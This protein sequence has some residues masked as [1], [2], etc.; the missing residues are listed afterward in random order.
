MDDSPNTLLPIMAPSTIPWLGFF[1]ETRTLFWT[2]D[3]EFVLRRRL[4]LDDL[5]CC[6]S[7]SESESDE[8]V[9]DERVKARDELGSNG[10]DAVVASE[11]LIA[12]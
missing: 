6:D 8:L 5:P 9:G 7:E 12:C 10:G 2:A 3:P 11:A 4:G 1:W